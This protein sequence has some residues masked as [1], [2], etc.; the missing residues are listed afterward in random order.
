M[1]LG[2]QYGMIARGQ[3]FVAEHRT[4]IRY[5]FMMLVE[6][7]VESSKLHANILLISSVQCIAMNSVQSDDAK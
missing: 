2:I 6:C 7:K 1:W 3:V 4:Q 5:D